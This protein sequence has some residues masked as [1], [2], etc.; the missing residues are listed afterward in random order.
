MKRSPTAHLKRNVRPR[1]LELRHARQA[2]QRGA[3]W[4]VAGRLDKLDR[5]IR[6]LGEL[7]NLASR[8]PSRTTTICE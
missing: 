7:R 1:Q 4:H 6:E 8:Q 2:Q 5:G 3:A